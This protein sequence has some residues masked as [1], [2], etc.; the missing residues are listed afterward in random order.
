MKDRHIEQS[1]GFWNTEFGLRGGCVPS[2]TTIIAGIYLDPE[3]RNPHYRSEDTMIAAGLEAGVFDL[4]RFHGGEGKSEAS[5]F[6]MI[7]VSQ[8]LKKLSSIFQE[9]ASASGPQTVEANNQHV[10]PLAREL[11]RQLYEFDN[12]ASEAFS[13]LRNMIIE[14]YFVPEEFLEGLGLPVS[15]ME[16]ATTNGL[17]T[18]YGKIAGVSVDA[19]VLWYDSPEHPV[20]FQQADHQALS[21]GPA[22][23][24]SSGERAGLLF[25]DTGR[26]YEHGA[27]VFVPN[28]TC[29][30]AI[31]PS[32][33]YVIDQFRPGFRT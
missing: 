14:Y 9:L 6:R 20:G 5:I 26:R 10:S 28:A 8:S 29:E 23:D 12:L 27:G 16:S 13:E 4:E 22:Y 33:A 32:L 30:K 31:S 15:R 7:E 1:R 17:A 19:D 24:G 2:I 21:L 3:G 11:Q 18:H 25:I